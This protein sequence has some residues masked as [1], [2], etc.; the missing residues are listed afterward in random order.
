MREKF[1]DAE[2]VNRSCNAEEDK[3]MAKKKRP[4][5]K[6]NRLSTKYYT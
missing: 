4:K 2:G 3:T 1:E 5:K 6:D